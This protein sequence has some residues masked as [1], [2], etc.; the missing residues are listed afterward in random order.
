MRNKEDAFNS[1]LARYNLML[2]FNYD[3]EMRFQVSPKL[4]KFCPIIITTDFMIN[5]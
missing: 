2:L 4:K 1:V 3:E 5:I